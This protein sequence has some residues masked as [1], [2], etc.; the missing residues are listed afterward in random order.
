[1][2]HVN[3][4]SFFQCR[5]LCVSVPG[6]IA[7]VSRQAVLRA[8][9]AAAERRG[10]EEMNEQATVRLLRAAL[11]DTLADLDLIGVTSI[12]SSHSTLALGPPDLP[13]LLL[14][15]VLAA[16][17][18]AGGCGDASNGNVHEGSYGR[19]THR[20]VSTVLRLCA[21][22]PQPSRPDAA[23]LC[24]VAT[25]VAAGDL[26]QWNWR[27]L[28]ML[29]WALATLR[30]ACGGVGDTV[31]GAAVQAA[32]AQAGH[33]SPQA[34]L[35]LLWSSAKTEQ[36]HTE[37]AVALFELVGRAVAQGPQQATGTGGSAAAGGGVARAVSAEL[38]W[39]AQARAQLLWSLAT[40]IEARGG[41]GGLTGPNGASKRLAAV[42]PEV[43]VEA[44]ARQLL[45]WA[46][47]SP[48]AVVKVRPSQQLEQ[49]KMGEG[50]ASTVLQLC[51]CAV[52]LLCPPVARVHWSQ[53]GG[54]DASG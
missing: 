39:D 31:V 53:K 48:G 36:S 9:H 15:R 11:R 18:G 49:P 17:G 45:R 12:A 2:L 30:D 25:S 28:W 42:W 24:A 4:P 34:L 37:G 20:A 35:L 40:A 51:N 1:M 47:A 29:A 21:R 10:P 46:A 50:P 8:Q 41:V 22:M 44:I 38:Q 33:L 7:H 14:R 52:V 26:T 13:E 54:H 3:V 6:K 32:A 5:A 27:S 43:P 16:L 19:H 23:L